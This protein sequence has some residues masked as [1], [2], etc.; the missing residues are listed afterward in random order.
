MERFLSAGS[1][2]EDTKALFGYSEIYNLSLWIIQNRIFSLTNR[3]SNWSWLPVYK[4]ND[5]AL[6]RKEHA[7]PCVFY[8]NIACE[9]SLGYMSTGSNTAMTGYMCLTFLYRSS[10]APDAVPA[11][12]PFLVST[13]GTFKGANVNSANTLLCDWIVTLHLSANLFIVSSL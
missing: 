5:M 2:R 6:I 4:R 8:L 1:D 11:V 3:K 7:T 13:A 12:A 9:K 10:V